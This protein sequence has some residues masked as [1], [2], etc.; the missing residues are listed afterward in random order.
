MRPEGMVF[1]LLDNCATAVRLLMED[2]RLGVEQ[3]LEKPRHGLL[4]FTIV[5][6]DVEDIVSNGSGV[7][8]RCCR[9]CCVQINAE[10]IKPA[11]QRINA[12]QLL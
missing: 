4:G 8:W 2:D 11:R 5:A 3:L 1:E 6:V 10:K 9:C 12:T 7:R